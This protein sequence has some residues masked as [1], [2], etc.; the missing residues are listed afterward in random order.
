VKFILPEDS[1]PRA[2]R[3]LDFV[4]EASKSK[5]AIRLAGRRNREDSIFI[6]CGI[7]PCLRKSLHKVFTSVNGVRPFPDAIGGRSS[8]GLPRISTASGEVPV[9][10]KTPALAPCLLRPQMH[11]HAIFTQAPY[12][13][14]IRDNQ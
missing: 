12:E 7:M 5:P 4:A 6:R 8:I 11:W 2:F 14:E 10:E 13:G 9:I 1:R 3:S